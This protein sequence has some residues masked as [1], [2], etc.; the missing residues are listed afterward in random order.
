M[1]RKPT[2]GVELGPPE[3]LHPLFLLTG[4]GGVVRGAWGLLAAGAYFATQGRWWI[5]AV[6]LGGLR[7]PID[8]R[9]ARALAQDRISG[10]GARNPHRHRAHQPDQPLDPVRPDPRRRYRAGPAAAPARPGP[11]PVRNRRVGCGGERG[12][13]A[14]HHLARAR[15]SDPRPHPRAPWR[16]GEC[17]GRQPTKT[18][19][20]CSRWTCAAC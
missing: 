13:G 5:V 4:L 6:M 19:R 7:D 17:S 15:R 18:K 11:G 12:R 8:R 2:A 9:A 14:P 20:H 10:R 3:R 16:G 1:L